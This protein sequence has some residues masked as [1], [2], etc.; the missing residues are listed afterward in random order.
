MLNL[1]LEKA[2]EPEI[3]CENLLDHRKSKRVPEKTSIFALLTTPKLLTVWITTNYGKF[4]KRWEY[5]TT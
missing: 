3:N 1:D 5:K 4:F 2:K